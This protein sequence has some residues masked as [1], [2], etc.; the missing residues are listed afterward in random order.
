M[1]SLKNNN[2]NQNIHPIPVSE[3]F[4]HFGNLHSS[5][6][7]DKL[8]P[9]QITIVRNTQVGDISDSLNTSLD[10][11]ITQEEIQQAMKHLKNKKA[12]GI[13]RIRNEMLKCG[14]I[15][16]LSVLVR[17]F[18]LV[19]KSGNYPDIWSNGVITSIYKSGDRSDPSNYRGICVS[20]CLGKLFCSI[21]NTRLQAFLKNKEVLL[22][23]WVSTRQQNCRSHFFIAYPY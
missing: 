22:S 17:L 6:E 8:S 18:N 15:K 9:D 12:P 1:K 13:D 11:E 3:L 14:R 21:L 2:G 23:D 19:L 7:E 16:L 4:T 10:L 5:V 20:S